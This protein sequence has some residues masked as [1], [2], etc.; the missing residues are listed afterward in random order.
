[1]RREKSEKF[2]SPRVD[3]APDDVSRARIRALSA[4]ALEDVAPSSKKRSPSSVL[5]S[6]VQRSLG[7]AASRRSRRTGIYPQTVMSVIS[8]TNV[9]LQILSEA[10]GAGTLG[11]V[12]PPTKVSNP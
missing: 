1:M 4:D 12:R 10:H 3:I 6:R 11:Y 9:T 7:H 8:R 5:L 2:S